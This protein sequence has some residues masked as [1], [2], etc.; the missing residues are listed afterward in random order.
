MPK[1]NKII[2]DDDVS[3]S[4]KIG[5]QGKV[6][7]HFGKPS[8]RKSEQSNKWSPPPKGKNPDLSPSKLVTF[9][10]KLVMLSLFTVLKQNLPS[11][12]LQISRQKIWDL[13][14]FW[15]ELS[16]GPTPSSHKLLLRRM[17][18]T[19]VAVKTTRKFMTQLTNPW[20]NACLKNVLK[21]KSVESWLF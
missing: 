10:I 2:N 6:W 1:R 5:N 4:L 3:S 18:V 15:K 19:S 8:A 14:S 7:T 11:A 12:P 9:D 21:T 20:L 16:S 17:A 13:W